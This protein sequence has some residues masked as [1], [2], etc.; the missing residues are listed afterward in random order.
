MLSIVNKVDSLI[1]CCVCFVCDK[2]IYFFY[3]TQLEFMCTQLCS[4][5]LVYTR[6]Y[7]RTWVLT[8]VCETP[9]KGP[10]LPIF[11]HFS[12]VSLLKSL[13]VN[14]ASKHHYILLLIFILALKTS[15]FIIFTWIENL[16][17]SSFFCSHHP[18]MLVGEALIGW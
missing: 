1:F 16:M 13:F 18:L 6:S 14:F 2:N 4:W 3:N 12:T 9:S 10:T 11:T 15:F 7:L 17:P 5:G 8:H